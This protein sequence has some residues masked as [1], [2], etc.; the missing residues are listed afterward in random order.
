MSATKIK[1]L[2]LYLT[3]F[4]HVFMGALVASMLLGWGLQFLG[5]L[6]G[7]TYDWSTVFIQIYLSISFLAFFPGQQLWTYR[8][9]DAEGVEHTIIGRPLENADRR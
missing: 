3:G 4:F 5:A 7:E 1:L 8:L 9:R 6:H 2:F